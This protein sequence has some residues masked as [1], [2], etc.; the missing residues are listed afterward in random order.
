MALFFFFIDCFQVVLNHKF[1]VIYVN[2][3]NDK[4]GSIKI[5]ACIAYNSGRQIEQCYQTVQVSLP[6]IDGGSPSQDQVSQYGFPHRHSDTVMH[7]WTRSNNK[8]TV[9]DDR[10]VVIVQT[11]G[12][13]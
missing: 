12:L 9:N 2:T 13:L 10:F 8:L 4:L 7:E 1:F 6:C 5:N 11:I 3:N